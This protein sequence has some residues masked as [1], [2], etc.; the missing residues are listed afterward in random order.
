MLT[1]GRSICVVTWLF[2][3]VTWLFRE[4]LE[5]VFYSALVIF[6]FHDLGIY[7]SWPPSI[8]QQSKTKKLAGDPVRGRT[9]PIRGR[10]FG[11][12]VFSL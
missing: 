4:W 8:K 7:S 2:R 10:T 3:V 12:A 9:G 5:D 1:I 6:P 11:C